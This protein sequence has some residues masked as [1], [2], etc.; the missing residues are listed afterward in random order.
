MSAIFVAGTDT[1][2]GKTHVSGLLLDFFL[3]EGV[4][5]G[6]QKWAATGP[7]SPPADLEACLRTAGLPLDLDPELVSRQVVYHFALPASPHLAAEQEGKVVDPALIR[8]RYQEMLARYELLVV[9]G[10]GGIMVPLN[11]ALLLADLL[12]E[13]KIPTLVVARSGLGTINHTLLTLEALRH[14]DIPVL[15]V[16]FSDG[17]TEED[18]LLVEDNMRTIAELGRVRVFGRLRRFADP[19]KA[20]L[21]FAPVG[22]AIAEALRVS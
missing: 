20:R 11:R 4:M 5:A 21:D 7:E 2:V 1:N 19:G 6:Y 22:K 15:G 12:R 18:A 17:A 8:L 3:K 9:E 13:L 16:V 14:R 10:V